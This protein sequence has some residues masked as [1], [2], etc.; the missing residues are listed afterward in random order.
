MTTNIEKI[1][2]NII[3]LLVLFTRFNRIHF[4]HT[5]SRFPVFL[6]LRLVMSLSVVHIA[7]LEYPPLRLSMFKMC[8]EQKKTKLHGPISSLQFYNLH[9]IP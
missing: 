8:M 3:T 4:C 7:L 9:D 2:K 5:L 1:Y 6:V